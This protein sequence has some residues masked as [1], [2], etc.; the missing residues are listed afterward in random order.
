MKYSL[1]QKYP[2]SETFLVLRTFGIKGDSEKFNIL[3]VL[4]PLQQQLL[5]DIITKDR[6]IIIKCI[7]QY[8]LPEE[9]HM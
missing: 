3:N 6:V 7:Q 4:W 1:T 2:E 5:C 9:C 8:L